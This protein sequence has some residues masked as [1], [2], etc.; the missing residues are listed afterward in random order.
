MASQT[1]QQIIAIYKLSNISRSKGN[2]E[3]KFSQLIKYSVENIFLKNY[4]ENEVWRFILDL[5]S[6][7]KK[8]LYKVNASVQHLSFNI[9]L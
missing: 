5:F 3:M 9:F 4:A 7:F 2:Q 1:G 6:V 8:V